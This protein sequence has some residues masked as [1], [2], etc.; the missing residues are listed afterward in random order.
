LPDGTTATLL[1]LLF[2]PDRSD[3]LAVVLTRDPAGKSPGTA[4]AV[5]VLVGVLVT[6]GVGVLVTVGGKRRS[7]PVPWLSGVEATS[8]TISIS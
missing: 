2:A 7:H 4:V 6:M 5:A 1:E 3:T 8:S